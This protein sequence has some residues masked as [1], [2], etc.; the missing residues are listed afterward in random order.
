MDRKTSLDA[1]FE[2]LKVFEFKKDSV[3]K[4]NIA[5]WLPT[6]HKNKFDMLQEATDKRFG[7]AVRDMIIAAIDKLCEEKY[8]DLNKTA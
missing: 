8:P 2:D 1:I 5:I 7:R 3:D 4:K 6:E